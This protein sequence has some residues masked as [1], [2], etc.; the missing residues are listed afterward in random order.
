MLYML[1]MIY[2]YICKNVYVKTYMYERI[3]MNDVC[4]NVYMNVCIRN[5]ASVKRVATCSD[6]Q[7]IS[8]V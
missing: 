8:S 4:M 5:R 2:E 3:C 1:Y 7:C 6:M